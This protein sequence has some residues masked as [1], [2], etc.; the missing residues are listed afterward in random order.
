MTSPR[1]DKPA[2]NPT[3]DHEAEGTGVPGLPTW[4]AVYVCLLVGFVAYVIILTVITRV[5]AP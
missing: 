3:A 4:R 5:Y 1:P 2:R